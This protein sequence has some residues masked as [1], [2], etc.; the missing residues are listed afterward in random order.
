M[1]MIT[2]CREMFNNFR[3]IQILDS[4]LDLW[5]MLMLLNGAMQTI[6]H[7]K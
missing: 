7:I 5:T 2:Q 6:M 1:L 3:Q 4:C